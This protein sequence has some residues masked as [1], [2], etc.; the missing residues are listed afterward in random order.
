MSVARQV[1]TYF[2]RVASGY[3]QASGNPLWG[4]VRLREQ[5]SF[6]RMLGPVAER[7]VLELG[8]GAGYYT[9]LVLA[10]GAKHVVACD[11]SEPMLAELPK[12]NVTP[13]HGDAASIDPGRKFDVLVSAG[14]LEFVPDPAAVFVNA[15]RFANPGAKFAILYP[16]RSLLGHL[17]QGFHRRNGMNIHL[18][19]PAGLRAMAEA[20]GWTITRSTSAGPYSACARLERRTA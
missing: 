20:A 12:A 6:L 10:E 18:F 11:F 4:R 5:R 16:T 15:A 17:Y 19:D 9:R 2:D 1:Q 8:C 14:M 13:L 3:Q 7:D